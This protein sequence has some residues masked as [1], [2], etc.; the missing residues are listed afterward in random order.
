MA[1]TLRVLFSGLCAFV[2]N[3]PFDQLDDP[4]TEVTVLLRNLLRPV[5]LENS[6]EGVALDPHYPLV[7]F[8]LADLH[9][10]SPRKPD[11]RR[12]D[13]GRGAC[14]LFGQEISFD[15][16][17]PEDEERK[18]TT[19]SDPERQPA[20]GDTRS[21]PNNQDSL[22]WL[23][24]I[25]KASPDHFVASRFI[26]DPLT[27]EEETEILARL[28]LTHGFLRASKLSDQ[29]C[30]FE[31]ANGNDHYEQQIATE[32]ALDIQ[33]VEGPAVIV[34]RAPDGSERNLMLSPVRRS[35]LLEIRI[36]NREID[37]LLGIPKALLPP[38]EMS[39]FQVFYDLVEPAQ[40]ATAT[41]RRFPKQP[42]PNG[43]PSLKN[44]SLCPPTEL[45]LKP[46][47]A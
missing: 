4:P 30:T 44:P 25:K 19:P 35:G 41:V 28:K 37:D 39:D 45:A 46:A 7:E 43:N 23:A 1:Y 15:L 13:T 38:R 18:L 22:Y 12:D 2:P 26:D 5:P 40:G 47:A 32:L 10:L 11:L 34:L 17:L 21:T 42:P 24:K 36:Q 8:D 6:P 31:P 3:K 27:L 20:Q 16:G 33:G 9:P 14:L 29:V